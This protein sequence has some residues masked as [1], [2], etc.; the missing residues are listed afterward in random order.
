MKS[1]QRRQWL[2]ALACVFA[3]PA[4]LALARLPMNASPDP[5]PSPQDPQ[6]LRVAAAISLKEALEAIAGDYERN[7]KVTLEFSFGSSGQLLAQIRNGAPLDAFIS[8]AQDQVDA[9]ER[10][11][12]I[13][14]RSR[15]IVAGNRLVL[16]APRQSAPGISRFQDLADDAMKRLAIGDPGTVP[17][18]QY[19]RQVL[20]HLKLADALK[21]RLVYGTNVRQVLDYVARGEVSAG[22]VYATD[23]CVQGRT[24]EVI[25][26]A[27]PAWHQPIE[28]PAV[29][30]STSRRPDVAQKFLDALGEP[31]ALD[32]FKRFGFS[33]PANA[34][35]QPARS[36]PSLLPAPRE[37]KP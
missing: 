15:R 5:A 37:P 17:A 34:A 28:Y 26:T 9:L 21:E 19:A 31:P 18:G 20:E 6:P 14:D 27:E 12:L 1:L 13:R 33:I 4:I 29:V 11:E 30:L 23:T 24:V 8:A 16:I 25:A 7:A 22:I 2:L 3:P 36:Q 32:V 10:D 35:S